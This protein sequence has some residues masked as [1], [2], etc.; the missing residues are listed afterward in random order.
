MIAGTSFELTEFGAV[1]SAVRDR[2]KAWIPAESI[3]Q[4]L[5]DDQ[6]DAAACL[7]NEDG[8]V[9][10]NLE[11]RG[12]G[13]MRAFV[14]I[15]VSTGRPGAFHRQE[16]AMLAIARDLG[17]VELAFRSDRPGWLRVLGPEWSC[18]FDLFYRSVP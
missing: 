15:A 6:G 18:D 4:A 7:M 14:L 1:W 10:V 2:A 17:A 12:D 11:G 5:V 9:V 8:L 3:A 16:R 13:T